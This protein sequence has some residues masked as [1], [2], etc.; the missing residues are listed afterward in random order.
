MQTG[1]PASRG[2]VAWPFA[3]FLKTALWFSPL[4]TTLAGRPKMP[5]A[6]KD[7]SSLAG[8]AVTS[9]P[10]KREDVSVLVVGASGGS[11]ARV[12]RELL[13]DGSTVRAMVRN[14]SSGTK[15]LKDIGV[16]PEQYPGRLEIV[17]GDLLNLRPEV[18]EGVNAVICAAG[19]R[20]GPAPKSPDG[21]A[22]N[23]PP[24]VTDSPPQTVE[25]QGVKALVDMAS[26]SLQQATQKSD[27]MAGT[28]PM[29]SFSDPE[30]VN[31]VWAPLDDIVMGGVSESSITVIDDQLVFAGIISTDNS[32]GFASGTHHCSTYCVGL[33]SESANF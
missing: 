12:V 25:Y 4:G 23:G 22:S 32:G 26:R 3:R 5:D 27:R 30:M 7:P 28:T 1:S 16:D 21:E 6:L 19:V 8:S 18:L 14:M 20:L 10:T 29:I 11:G 31:A 15:A 2:R 33:A 13:K 24:L 17:E 9:T